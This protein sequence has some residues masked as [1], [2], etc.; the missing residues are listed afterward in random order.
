MKYRLPGI[1]LGNISMDLFMEYMSN[2][3]LSNQT[4][5]NDYYQTNNRTQNVKVFKVEFTYNSVD[6]NFYTYNILDT[7]NIREII[8][9]YFRDIIS[10]TPDYDQNVDAIT[11]TVQTAD[12]IENPVLFDTLGQPSIYSTYMINDIGE[13]KYMISVEGELNEDLNNYTDLKQYVD[14]S[15]LELVPVN[16]YDLRYATKDLIT[17]LYVDKDVFNESSV[18]LMEFV[19]DVNEEI[20]EVKENVLYFGRKSLLNYIGADG[21]FYFKDKLGGLTKSPYKNVMMWD[22][23]NN[24]NLLDQS[25]QIKMLSP[26]NSRNFSGITGVVR[27]QTENNDKVELNFTKYDKYSI[28]KQFKEVSS[29]P[30]GEEDIRFEDIEPKIINTIEN[31]VNQTH[32]FNEKSMIVYTDLVNTST[33]PKFKA[34]YN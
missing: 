27:T 11:F 8:R 15:E 34:I 14:S 5:T 2:E 3:E 21:L 33:L 10:D 23:E 26:E 6:Y 24:R 12:F 4:I 7:V 20:Q 19:L 30:G 29:I 16:I 13:Y 9:T 32:V 18:N 28:T 1:Y 17:T 31:A 25:I 22:I